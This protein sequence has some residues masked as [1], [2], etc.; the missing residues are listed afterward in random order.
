MKN[1]FSKTTT[2]LLTILIVTLAL[3]V[4]SVNFIEQAPPFLSTPPQASQHADTTIQHLSLS[5]FDSEGR[6]KYTLESPA[7]SHFDKQEKTAL[8]EPRIH[9]YQQDKSPWSISAQQGLIQDGDIITLQGDVLI[10]GKQE[11]SLSD[12]DV[13]TETLTL[14]TT[15]RLAKT[16]A[17]VHIV[18]PNSRLEAMGLQADLLHDT[19]TLPAQVQGTY[20]QR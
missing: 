13:R 7:L 18:A 15:E 4:Y 20:L 2:S 8:L 6:L 9:L 5:V 1:T 16:N 11:K 12:I 17:K 14:L 3:F 10:K 19:L